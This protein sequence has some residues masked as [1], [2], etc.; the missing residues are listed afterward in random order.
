MIHTQEAIVCADAR[1]AVTKTITGLSSLFRKM[2]DMHPTIQMRALRFMAC[3]AKYDPNDASKVTLRDNA[4]EFNGTFDVPK[5][6]LLDG[7]FTCGDSPFAFKLSATAVLGGSF[8]LFVV[9]H[10]VEASTG[11]IERTKG[12]AREVLTFVED[13]VETAMRALMSGVRRVGTARHEE[14]SSMLELVSRY[15]LGYG[16][17]YTATRLREMGCAFLLGAQSWAGGKAMFATTVDN[18]VVLF[19]VTSPEALCKVFEA[20]DHLDVVVR[21]LKA[22]AELLA[23]TCDTLREHGTTFV[24]IAS[25]AEFTPEGLPAQEPAA[26]TSDE[27]TELADEEPELP[28]PKRMRAGSVP[29]VPP[30]PCKAQSTPQQRH[31]TC[32]RQLTL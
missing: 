8:G 12:A 14:F 30:P 32:A 5:S 6:P 13:N 1:D 19:A 3:D 25:V 15:A 21:G 29:P 17:S 10:R 16:S 31:G 22:Y 18:A 4:A 9:R 2:G 24:D 7:A 27:H 28:A 11:T 26:S 20:K 23:E